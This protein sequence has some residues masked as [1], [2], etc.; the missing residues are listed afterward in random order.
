MYPLKKY[1]LTANR[2]G[3]G[4]VEIL[5]NNFESLSLDY[6]KELRRRAFELGLSIYSISIHNNFVNPST[7]ERSKE[8]EKVKK[9]LNV[10][11]TLGATIARVNS[12]RWGTIKSFDEL[13]KRKGVEPPISGYT[14][15]DAISWVKESMEKLVPVAEELGVIIGME[16]HWGV[17]KTARNMI[18]L[19]SAVRSDYFR[20]ILDTGNFIE[21]TYQQ[22]KSIAPFVAMVQAKT[23]FGGGEWYTLD[24]NYDTV[25]DILKKAG[26]DGWVS[27]EY[28]GK[29]PY[30]Q[31]V[32]MSEELLSK[33]ISRDFSL[34]GH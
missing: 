30:E 16:N 14:D 17:S 9:M 5:E 3:F 26:F 28:E 22:M 33:Y 21:K 8:L 13:M 31:G 11:Y 32:S 2:L 15:E 34:T 10:A 25:F 1:L 4:G 7:I 29:T 12:G 20:A 19:F 23:Y 24:L 6:L 18:R 27:L